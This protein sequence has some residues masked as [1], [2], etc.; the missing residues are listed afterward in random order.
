MYRLDFIEYLKKE[1]K[2]IRYLISI[3]PEDK[4]EWSP[5]DNLMNLGKLVNHL[6]RTY[7]VIWIMLEKVEKIP[8]EYLQWDSMPREEALSVFDREVSRALDAMS[9]VSDEDY[10]ES[11]A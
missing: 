7:A 9:K 11:R 3:V 1:A 10:L 8:D 6:A 2:P 5:S 4:Y